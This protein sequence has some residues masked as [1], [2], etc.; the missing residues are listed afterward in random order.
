MM[1][2]NFEIHICISREGDPLASTPKVEGGKTKTM[3]IPS[4][5]AQKLLDLRTQLLLHEY[6]DAP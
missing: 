2:S 3:P 1:P 4:D 5:L 6:R